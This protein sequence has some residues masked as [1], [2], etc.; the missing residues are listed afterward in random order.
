MKGHWRKLEPNENGTDQYGSPVKGKTWVKRGGTPKVDLTL[1]V[2]EEVKVKVPSQ[3]I[4][5]VNSGYSEASAKDLALWT[6]WKETQDENDLVN[7]MD[8]FNGS[9]AKIKYMFSDAPVPPSVIEA[10]CNVAVIE[11]IKSYDPKGGSTLNQWINGRLKG[12]GKVVGKY[13][14]VGKIPEHRRVAI[15]AYKDAMN[16]LEERLGHPPSAQALAEELKWSITEVT[17]MENE[18]S[19]RDL[20]ASQQLD[21]DE[22]EHLA[23]EAFEKRVFR[24]VYYSL[25]DDIERLVFE[26]TAGYNG[27]EELPAG[28]IAKKLNIHPSKVSRI[29]NKIGKMFDERGL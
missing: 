9:V 11:G 15:A 25:D 22:I 18:L 27:K 8:R 12:V 7:L 1:K 2:P 5:V 17:R 23:D 26:Y 13:Q 29:R 24:N 4:P 16:N 6:I 20:I 19:R 3:D 14:N 21:V 10:A 28:D